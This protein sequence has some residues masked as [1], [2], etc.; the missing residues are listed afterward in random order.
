MKECRICDGTGMIVEDEDCSDECSYCEGTGT[1]EID[2][3]L[4][5]DFMKKPFWA[6][7]TCSI[8]FEDEK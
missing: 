6:T 3:S 7:T 4:C 2:D 5:P 8:I 1:E